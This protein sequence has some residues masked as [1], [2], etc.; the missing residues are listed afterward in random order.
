LEVVDVTRAVA[1][2][3][4]FE[5]G[6]EGRSGEAALLVRRMKGDNNA[7]NR[8]DIGDA[9]LV[10][11]LVIELDPVRAWDVSLNDLTGNGML[12]SGDVT[13]VLRVVV[14]LD[15]QPP[16]GGGML[17]GSGERR[18]ANGAEGARTF[19]SATGEH[20]ARTATSAFAVGGNADRLLTAG[21]EERG[22]GGRHVVLQSA[23]VTPQS[24]IPEMALLSPSALPI[25]SGQAVALQVVLTNIQGQLAGATFT[26]GYPVEALALVPGGQKV[27]SIVPAG[28]ATLWNTN[29]AGKV[30]LALSGATAWPQANGVLAELSFL[31][32]PGATAQGQWPLTLSGVEVTPDGYDNRVLVSVGALLSSGGG[33]IEAPEIDLEQSGLGPEGFR[34]VFEGQAGVQYELQRSN[35]LQTWFRVQERAGTAGRF[36]MLDEAALTRAGGFYR[37]KASR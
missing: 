36:K 27:G 10:Q 4:R 26:V 29:A 6:T 1:G 37:V 5:Y 22:A 28:T 25:Q 3:P 32:L 17:M 9:T 34:V 2:S 12:D 30:S 16:L 15:P 24:A 19:L 33:V 14:G 7:N 23:I 13:Q 31:I 20:G 35:D 11:R 18:A 8:L 21:E